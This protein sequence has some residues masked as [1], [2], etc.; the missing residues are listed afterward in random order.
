MFRCN[1][2][3]TFGPALASSLLDGCYDFDF[4]LVFEESIF[5]IGPCALVLPFAALRLYQLASR[6]VL[7][8]WPLLQAIKLVSSKR[9]P[10]LLFPAL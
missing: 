6:D 5:A 8:R 3:E 10:N 2:D 7:V 1:G 4:T 9:W